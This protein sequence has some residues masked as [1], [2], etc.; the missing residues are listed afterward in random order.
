MN[1]RIYTT[2]AYLEAI[3]VTI[4]GITQ[5]RWIVDAFEDDSYLYGSGDYCKPYTYADT[6]E[7]MFMKD[8]ES[9]EDDMNECEMDEC[10]TD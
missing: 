7:G 4:N 2:G 1:T 6:L 8:D 5:Y 10:L 3:E 9:Y